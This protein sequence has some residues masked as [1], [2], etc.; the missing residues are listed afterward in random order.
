[1]NGG[2]VSVIVGWGNADYVPQF[3]DRLRY[4]MMS[5]GLHSRQWLDLLVSMPVATGLYLPQGMLRSALMLE[6]KRVSSSR[7]RDE[8]LKHRYKKLRYMAFIPS[9]PTQWLE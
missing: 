7:V 3:Y 8:E 2:V 5:S 4:Y 6:Y 1:M 9:L